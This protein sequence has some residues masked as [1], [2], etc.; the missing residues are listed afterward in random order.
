ME[1]PIEFVEPAKLQSIC[2]QVILSNSIARNLDNCIK[3][4]QL[5]ED[6]IL[7]LRLPAVFPLYD[8]ILRKLKISFPVLIQNGYTLEQLKT[9]FKEIDWDAIQSDFLSIQAEKNKFAYLKGTV[10]E[11][12]VPNISCDNDSAVYPLEAL[13]EGVAW[14]ANVDPK[15]RERFLAD[16]EFYKIFHMTKNEFANLPDFKRVRLK[17]QHKLF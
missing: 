8:L 7:D 10:I 4:Y 5:Y 6:G 3:F 15:N 17:Q 9:S 12:A 1:E 11:R 14:P 16:D 13:L 2:V